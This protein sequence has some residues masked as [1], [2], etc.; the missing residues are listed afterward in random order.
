MQP[1][2]WLNR[3]ENRPIHTHEYQLHTGSLTHNALIT[4]T[5]FLLYLAKSL[6]SSLFF[7][8]AYPDKHV[9]LWLAPLLQFF[10]LDLARVANVQVVDSWSSSVPAG[11]QSTL[12]HTDKINTTKEMT[13]HLWEQWVMGDLRAFKASSQSPQLLLSWCLPAVQVIPHVLRQH[14]HQVVNEC[15]FVGRHTW[16]KTSKHPSDINR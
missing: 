16:W 7:T 14:Y 15:C 9:Q 1:I 5:D 12:T 6:S 8:K 3:L 4:H 2:N 13:V 10:Y 11:E